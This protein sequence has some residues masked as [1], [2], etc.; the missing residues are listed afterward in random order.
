VR[1]FALI[2]LAIVGVV[3]TTLGVAL[4]YP[5]AALILFGVACVALALVV[6]V[7]DT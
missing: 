3:C 5:P 4:I 1:L 6:E 2:A 7:R